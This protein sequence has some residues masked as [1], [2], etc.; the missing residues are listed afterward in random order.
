M[1][2]RAGTEHLL[3]PPMRKAVHGHLAH[4]GPATLLAQPQQAVLHQ[5]GIPAVPPATAARIQVVGKSGDQFG[6]GLSRG[7]PDRPGIKQARVLALLFD[8]E[9]LRPLLGPS[10]RGM[11]R[12]MNSSN[13]GTVNAV[14]P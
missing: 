12:F 11:V 2:E 7:V 3:L 9:L 1:I 5:P 6:Q 13:K 14:S 8:D 4:V 10:S